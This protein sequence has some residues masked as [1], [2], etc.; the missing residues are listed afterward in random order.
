TGPAG[1]PVSATARPPALAAG[2]LLGVA[3]PKGWVA[4]AAVFGSARLATTPAVDAAAK[5]AVLATMIVLITTG[6]LL[7]GVTLA[8]VL[9]GPRR[10]RGGDA[11]LCAAPVGAAAPADAGRGDRRGVCLMDLQPAAGA[12]SALCAKLAEAHTPWQR[13]RLRLVTPVAYGMLPEP[14]VRLS[15]GFGG[16]GQLVLSGDRNPARGRFP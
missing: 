4:I 15:A 12:Q 5:V 9:H 13:P 11:G 7:A 1:P 3:N 14:C 6:W 8:T 16:V 2:A 10:G